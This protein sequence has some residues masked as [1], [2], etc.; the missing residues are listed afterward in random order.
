M[1]AG[2]GVFLLR[3]GIDFIPFGIAQHVILECFTDSFDNPT[4]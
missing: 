3:A 2:V 1:V 4:C